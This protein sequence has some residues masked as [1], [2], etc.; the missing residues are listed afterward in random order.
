MAIPD[1]LQNLASAEEFLDYFKLS[2]DPKV[3]RV[4]RLHILQRFHAYLGGIPNLDSL[5]EK[6]QYQTYASALQQAYGDFVSSTPQKEK[7]FKVFHL[8]EGT[9]FVP[10]DRIAHR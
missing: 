9:Q 5:D 1:D 10:V 8:A 2:Y 7:V 4:S 3:V 6:A